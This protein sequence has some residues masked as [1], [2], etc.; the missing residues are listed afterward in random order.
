MTPNKVYYNNFLHLVS[1]VNSSSSSI[2]C[3]SHSVSGRCSTGRHVD[4]NKNVQKTFRRLVS[5]R[6]LK[7]VA[8]GATSDLKAAHIVP[9]EQSELI[10]R[11]LLFSPENG[12]LLRSDIEDDYDRHMWIFDHNGSI[13]VLYQNWKHRN[14]IKLVTIGSDHPPSH[15]LINLHNQMAL[16]KA[17]HHCPNCWKYVGEVNIGAHQLSSCENINL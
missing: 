11:S 15:E 3:K 9:L 10:E 12:V 7:C 13:D 8:T 2:L 14:S 5:K 1:S 17:K 6:D 4:R 16:D